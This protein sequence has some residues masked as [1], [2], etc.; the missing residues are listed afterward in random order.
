MHSLNHTEQFNIHMSTSVIKALEP[1][2]H[3]ALEKT[4]IPVELVQ[5]F[6]QT[7]T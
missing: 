1:V 3:C 2:T 7:Q 4:F 6:A 5:V